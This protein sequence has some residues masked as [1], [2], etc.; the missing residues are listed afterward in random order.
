[1][2]LRVDPGSSRPLFEQIAASVRGEI[3]RGALVVGDRLPGAR[4]VAHE[5]GVNHHTVL[6]A[7]QELRDEGVVE[8]RRGRGAVVTAS[9]TEAGLLHLKVA[10]LVDE[11]RSLGMADD[12]LVSLVRVAQRGA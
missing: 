5:L 8:L 6:R 10:S 11:A 4:D 7:Y 3:A 1:M 9:A 2:L 12:A